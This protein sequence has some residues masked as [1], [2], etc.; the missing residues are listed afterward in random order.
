M[1]SPLGKQLDELDFNGLEAA[2]KALDQGAELIAGIARTRTAPV[3]QGHLRQSI[4]VEA[5]QKFK[6]GVRVATAFIERIIRADTDYAFI[7]HQ[8][9][10]FDHPKGG[11]ANYLTDPEKENR[12]KILEHVAKAIRGE[13]K[14]MAAKPVV[15]IIE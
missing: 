7:Q 9:T 15:E 13:V 5:T 8:R 2:E 1:A 11:Q 6:R 14:R 12:T 4:T 10:D 3:D